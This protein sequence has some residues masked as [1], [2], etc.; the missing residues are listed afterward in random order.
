MPGVLAFMYARDLLLGLKRVWCKLPES[1]VSAIRELGLRRRQ[2]G[3]W[4][5]RNRQRTI[6]VPC[7]AERMGSRDRS[8]LQLPDSD[9]ELFNG[10]RTAATT[11]IA[12]IRIPLC[13]APLCKNR[14]SR[15]HSPLSSNKSHRHSYQPRRQIRFAFLNVRSMRNKIEAIR[16]RKIDNNI[17]VFC[18]T[19][20]WHEESD[21]IS[22][23][24]L[25]ADGLQVLERPR[26]IKHDARQDNLNLSAQNYGG[27][28][29]V[30]PELHPVNET[31]I[32]V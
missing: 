29:I 6:H 11:L 23:R 24:R 13:S 26:P 10:H 2:R 31:S 12:G 19:E 9:R 14:S 20:T 17:D 22:I 21:S 4:A 27:V 32:N 7:S 25:L 8:V 3:I 15:R 16:E 18:L 28:A 30:T 5:G 1:A